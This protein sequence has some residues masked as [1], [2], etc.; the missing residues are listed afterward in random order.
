MNNNI[1][2][3]KM[4]LPNFKEIAKQSLEYIKIKDQIYNRKLSSYYILDFKEFTDYCPLLIPSFRELG[5]EPR[6]ISIF[7]M[8]NN[9]H[10]PVHI[11]LFPPEAKFLIPL[12]NTE[13]TKTNF[14]GN[15]RVVR[16]TNPVSG[17][18][19]YRPIASK[20]MTLNASLELDGPAVLRTS[21]PHNVEMIENKFPRISMQVETD[22]DCVCFLDP[23]ENN[24]VTVI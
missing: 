18:K 6:L 11:D 21:S 7:I 8:Y 12:L 4:N 20:E 10:G 14:F 13:E 3:K 23:L 19:S 15:C 17:I 5:L 9:T 22:P 1:Y 24:D 16:V 2:F